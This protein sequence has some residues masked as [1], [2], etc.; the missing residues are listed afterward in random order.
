MGRTAWCVV[1]SVA[2]VLTIFHQVG[3]AEPAPPFTLQLLGGGTIGSGDLRGKLGVLRF[4]AS[5]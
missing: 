1:G 5:W 3:S 4:M 2:L